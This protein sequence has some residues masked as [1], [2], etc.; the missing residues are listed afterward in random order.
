MVRF[1]T[2]SSELHD[3]ARK[4]EQIC[5]IEFTRCIEA[6]ATL[7]GIAPHHPVSAN[8]R[9]RTRTARIVEYDNVVAIVIED[10]EVALGR[11][12]Y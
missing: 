7:G 8:D 1:D 12:N 4:R 3:L 5:D 11:G 9:L 6:A 2:G 10:V